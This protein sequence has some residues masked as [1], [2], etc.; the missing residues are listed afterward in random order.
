MTFRKTYTPD[1]AFQKIRHYCAYQERTHLEVKQKLRGFGL[2]SSDTEVLISRLIEENFLNEERFAIAFAGGRFR[3]KK[4]GRV[5][6]RY[7][8]GQKKVSTYN[9]QKGLDSISE[10]DYLKVLEKLARTKWDA[11]A[12]S[13]DPEHVK[14]ARTTSYLIQKGYETHLIKEVIGSLR[15]G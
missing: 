8:L 12:V 10:E 11:F 14:A 3:I 15:S 6:I 2:K 13:G 7:E 9:I 4:W 5:K 1:Q